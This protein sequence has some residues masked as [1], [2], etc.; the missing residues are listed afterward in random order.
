M[1]SNLGEYA[2]KIND[3]TVYWLAYATSSRVIRKAIGNWQLE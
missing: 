2:G 3:D 1:G